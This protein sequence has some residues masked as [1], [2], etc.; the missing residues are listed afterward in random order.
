MLLHSIGRLLVFFKRQTKSLRFGSWKTKKITYSNHQNETK[1]RGFSDIIDASEQT[2]KANTKADTANQP[3]SPNRKKKNKM[4][5]KK[6]D[7]V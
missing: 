5:K 6:D 7:K 2:R 3:S 1:I 4:D